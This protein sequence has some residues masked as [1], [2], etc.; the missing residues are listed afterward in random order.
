MKDD[1][2]GIHLFGTSKKLLGTYSVIE[3][4]IDLAVVQPQLLVDSLQII[5]MA[6]VRRIIVFEV[7]GFQLEADPTWCGGMLV[8]SACRFL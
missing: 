8:L 1:F 4:R 2:E 6:S 5:S 3:I 7:G